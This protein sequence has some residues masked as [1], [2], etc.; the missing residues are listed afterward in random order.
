VA[1][2]AGFNAYAD[3]SDAMLFR[4]RT[5]LVFEFVIAIADDMRTAIPENRFNDWCS[6]RAPTV[7]ERLLWYLWLF[8]FLI[9]PPFFVAAAAAAVAVAAAVVAA[10]PVAAA[11]ADAAAD[12]APACTFKLDPIITS[13]FWNMRQIRRVVPIPGIMLNA[14]STMSIDALAAPPIPD[15]TDSLNFSIDSFNFSVRVLILSACSSPIF[16]G[17]F[18]SM[19]IIFNKSFI[20]IGGSLDGV[21]N[22]DLTKF[23]IGWTTTQKD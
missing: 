14:L 7:I 10:T 6:A 13:T 20:V 17:S 8:L 15:T 11:A 5:R 22:I 2:V 4:S 21:V 19:P 1:D 3:M 12:V 9:P 23:I 16:S 18:K